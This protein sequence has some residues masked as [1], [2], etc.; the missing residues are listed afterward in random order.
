MLTPFQT[1]TFTYPS[2][3]VALF[4]SN[5]NFQ[6]G[7]KHIYRICAA[8]IATQTHLGVHLREHSRWLPMKA[9]LGCHRISLHGLWS[10]L[11][12]QYLTCTEFKNRHQSDGYNNLAIKAGC[13]IHTGNMY[14]HE[15]FA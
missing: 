1:D 2:F 4:K 7:M 12:P 13:F 11:H 15:N 6:K 14:F 3:T 8:H 10:L 9:S 5:L